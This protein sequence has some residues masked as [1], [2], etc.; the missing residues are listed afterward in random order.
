M[1]SV[2]VVVCCAVVFPFS[3]TRAF[4]PGMLRVKGGVTE[5]RAGNVRK[6]QILWNKNNTKSASGQCYVKAVSSRDRYRNCIIFGWERNSMVR[7]CRA[8][9]LK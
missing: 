8:Q 3:M 2:A 9:S 7:C 4:V 5:P 1:G 6:D